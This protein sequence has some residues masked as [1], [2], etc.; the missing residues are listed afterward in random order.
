M[1]AIVDENGTRYMVEHPEQMEELRQD[2][3]KK[4]APVV[5]RTA[6]MVIEIVGEEG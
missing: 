6:E 3:I 2:V 5:K 4:C 1:A